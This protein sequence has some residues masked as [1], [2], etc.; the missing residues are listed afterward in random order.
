MDYV[1]YWRARHRA[2]LPARSAEEAEVLSSSASPESMRKVEYSDHCAPSSVGASPVVELGY[3]VELQNLCKKTNVEEDAAGS[4]VMSVRKTTQRKSSD[5][6]WTELFQTLRTRVLKAHPPLGTLEKTNNSFEH[7]LEDIPI[8]L[9][10]VVDSADLYL[11]HLMGKPVSPGYLG[12]YS[13]A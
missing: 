9:C 12:R 8:A 1:D 2:S 6:N 13:I 7:V 10:E 4:R 11:R 3:H 5:L